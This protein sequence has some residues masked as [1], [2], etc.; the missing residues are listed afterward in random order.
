MP[1]RAGRLEIAIFLTVPHMAVH[2][3]FRGPEPI[4]GLD[5]VFDLTD[6]VSV[7]RELK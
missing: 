3:R 2:H 6:A 5:R 1:Y 7:S 4:L